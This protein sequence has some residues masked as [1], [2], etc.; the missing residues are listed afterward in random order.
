[1]SDEELPAG[2]IAVLGGGLL[3]GLLSSLLCL[4]WFTPALTAFGA[5]RWARANGSKTGG[6]AIGLGVG[7]V[8]GLVVATLGTL[9]F[10][11]L[12]DPETF[13][14]S[15]AQAQAL[16]G[17]G[18]AELTRSGVAVFHAFLG[19]G[20]AFVFGAVG[21]LLA[22]GGAPAPRGDDD[23]A[24]RWTPASTG[25][26]TGGATGPA[27]DEAPTD[28]GTP[29]AFAAAPAKPDPSAPPAPAAAGAGAA[30]SQGAAPAG[31]THGA[32]PESSA[33]DAPPTSASEADAWKA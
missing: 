2:T 19:G 10:L 15:L 22:G 32:V 18:G 7:A 14:E 33:E 20:F 28:P 1:M 11:T 29:V 26:P 5:A 13:D 4:C 27:R 23:P 30:L 21:G 31:P 8:S 9:A 16:M 24:K 17:G 6:A 12:N 3:G 25:G